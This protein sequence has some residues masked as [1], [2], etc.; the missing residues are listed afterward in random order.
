[1]NKQFSL[2]IAVLFLASCA[3]IYTP[4]IVHTPL[5]SEKND[6][7]LQI[8]MGTSGYDVQAAYAPTN[9][10][11]VMVN[12]SFQYRDVT[13]TNYY[14]KHEFVEA[15]VGYYGKIDE[16][17]RYECYLGYGNGEA[18]SYSPDFYGLVTG[19]YNRFF[20]QPSIGAKMDVFE[21]AFSLRVAYVDMYKI[22]KNVE[23]RRSELN[24]FYFEPVLTAKVGYKF[25]K[26]FVQG[27]LSL[28]IENTLKY[29]DSPL[30]LNFGLSFSFSK[31]Y[32]KAKE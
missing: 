16:A 21:G 20:I 6:A 32:L 25:V 14:H 8:G 5:F 23:Y 2:I 4:N 28:P 12:S 27:G 30:L 1:M 15:A 22:S 26:F 31:A 10:L 13:D 24:S 3:P 17:G 9:Y 11:G 19:S 7:D 18:K 29:T